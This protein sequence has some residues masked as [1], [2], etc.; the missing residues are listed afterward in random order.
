MRGGRSAGAG[1]REVS[2]NK[3]LIFKLAKL[4]LA[5]P[6]LCCSALSSLVYSFGLWS[7]SNPTFPATALPFP[8]CRA[9]NSNCT[10]I[11]I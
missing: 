10:P 6:R 1:G 4:G 9:K 2:N 7:E 11:G 5:M 8:P 3:I